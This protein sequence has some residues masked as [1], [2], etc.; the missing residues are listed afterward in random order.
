MCVCV[1]LCEIMCGEVCVCV[2]VG[3]EV[4]C[5]IM[6]VCVCVSVYVCEMMWLN[7]SSPLD[8]VHNVTQPPDKTSLC[9]CALY[10]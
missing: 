2:Y 6:Y 7:D 5:E 10:M 8:S 4:V 9:Q 3:G 1:T